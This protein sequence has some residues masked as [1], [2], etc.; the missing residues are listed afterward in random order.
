MQNQQV[1]FQYF[2][3]YEVFSF[4]FI[5]IMVLISAI[6]FYL[7]LIYQLPLHWWTSYTDRMGECSSGTCSRYFRWSFSQKVRDLESEAMKCF[8]RPFLLLIY[9]ELVIPVLLWP[10]VFQFINCSCIDQSLSELLANAENDIELC[11]YSHRSICITDKT[12]M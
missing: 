9:C 7:R 4:G 12:I 3:C 6:N 5:C 2:T 8:H 1:F 11:D 10:P